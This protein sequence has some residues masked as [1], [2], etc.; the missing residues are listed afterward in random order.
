MRCSEPRPV[1]TL[2]LTYFLKSLLTRAVAHIVLVRSL[3]V[4]TT[5]SLLLAAP[6]SFVCPSL[7]VGSGGALTERDAIRLVRQLPEFHEFQRVARRHHSAIDVSD[8]E[9]VT[10]SSRL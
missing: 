9:L 6:L 5:R 1:L 10:D 7:A 8:N 4:V 2:S 3:R